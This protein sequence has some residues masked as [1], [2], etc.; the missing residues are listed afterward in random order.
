MYV[1]FSIFFNK[2]SDFYAAVPVSYWYVIFGLL[3]CNDS[4]NYNLIHVISLQQEGIF[5]HSVLFLYLQQIPF[6]LGS[7]AVMTMAFMKGNL[8]L[9][10]SLSLRVLPRLFVCSLV[11]RSGSGGRGVCARE[12]HGEQ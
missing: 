5:P 3:K 9:F 12:E 7:R 2:T 4:G 11:L 6:S 10:F 8:F 1:V